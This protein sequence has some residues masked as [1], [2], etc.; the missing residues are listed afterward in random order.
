MYEEGCNVGIL[1]YG[2]EGSETRGGALIMGFLFLGTRK[3]EE[4]GSVKFYQS[5]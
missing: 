2:R 5:K 3:G 1:V 4:S